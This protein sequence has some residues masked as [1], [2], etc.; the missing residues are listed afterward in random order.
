M[1]MISGTNICKSLN[2]LTMMGLKPLYPSETRSIPWLPM[3]WLLA[4]P[5]HQHSATIILTYY[6]QDTIMIS[7]TNICKSLNL[8][9]MMG[10]KPLYP[11]ETR[12]IPWLP[13]SW[14]LV[15]PG[16]QHSA[17][18]ILTYYTQD[19]IM[20]SGTNL[21]KSLNLLTM[22]GLKPLFRSETRSI[23]WLPM[24]WLLASPG[25][26]HSAATVLTYF[27]QDAIMI[28]GTDIRESE[29]LKHICA[30]SVISQ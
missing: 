10:L 4:S 15:S 22:M 18:T 20:I 9:T 3:S 25:H 21:C 2:L 7:G 16:H 17:T 13:M 27:T 26:Q 12:S 11:S 24:S 1:I 6:K 29:F 14:L 5:G 30:K 28:S 8:L 23:P 19:T